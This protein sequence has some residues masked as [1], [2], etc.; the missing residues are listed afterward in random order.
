M[1]PTILFTRLVAM[2]QKED[3]IEQQFAFEL[4]PEP[5]ALFKDGMMR[6]SQ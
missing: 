4:T 1:D 6:K 3:D 5:T 2:A